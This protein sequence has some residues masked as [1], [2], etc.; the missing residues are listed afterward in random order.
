MLFARLAIVDAPV[1]PL[2]QPAR[3]VQTNGGSR[4]V[5]IVN[6]RRA[7][8][9]IAGHILEVLIEKLRGAPAHARIRWI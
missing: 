2:P 1:G 8:L 9:C 4:I 6:Q 5:Q 7:Q 3:S